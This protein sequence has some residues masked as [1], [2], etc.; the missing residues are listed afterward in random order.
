MPW[1]TLADDRRVSGPGRPRQVHPVQHHRPGQPEL[2]VARMRSD[3]LE[4][5]GLVRLVEPHDRRGGH[6]SVRRLHQDVQVA[7]I[8]RRL[9][10]TLIALGRVRRG[11]PGVHMGVAKPSTSRATRLSARI[12]THGAPGNFCYRRPSR[13]LDRRMTNLM[14]NTSDIDTRGSGRSSAVSPVPRI[15][16]VKAWDVHLKCCHD[17]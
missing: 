15:E 6:C 1:R 4:P 14:H 13:F 7:A 3:R 16:V 9:P 8:G 5:D 17:L 12:L 11:S 2:P 10:D